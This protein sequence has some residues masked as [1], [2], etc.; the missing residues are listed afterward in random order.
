MDVWYAAY[1]SN[2]L[3]AR[4]LTYLRGGEVPGS[5]RMQH[6]ARDATDPR[7]SRPYRLDRTMLFGGEAGGWQGRGVCFVDPHRDAPG[8][9]L[10]RAWLLTTE[11]LADVWAQENGSTVGPA[12]D[13]GELAAAGSAD[14]GSGWY[15]RLEY[16][17]ELDGLP[18][19]TITCEV[20]PE[21]NP[22]GL[23]YAS[24]VGR[25]IVETWGLSPQEATDY[26]IARFGPSADVDGV[27]LALAIGS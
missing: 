24:I 5:G 7:D 22:P 8:D 9:T 11:Q 27:D 3:E 23:D 10:G 1:G 25:G 26:L 12:I 16:L 13:L 17:G 6:G 21:R 2:L 15:R 19:A 4:F 18:V 20:A 14:L